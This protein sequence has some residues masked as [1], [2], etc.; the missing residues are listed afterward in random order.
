MENVPNQPSQRERNA[1]KIIGYGSLI[2]CIL[3]II[4]NFIALDTQTAKTLL[5]QA[6][7]KASGSAVDNILNSFRYTGVMYILAYL[8]GVIALWNR[9]KYLWWFMFAVYV[10]NVLFTL[11][12][13]A[14]VTNAIIS[15]KSPLFVVPVFIVI[16]GSALLAIYMLVVS[17]MRKSTFNR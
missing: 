6:G 5:S 4:H 3:L 13:I 9:H 16:I 10:S 2:F 15:A 11:V 7:Q 1:G 12:N 8:A 17:M 14:M